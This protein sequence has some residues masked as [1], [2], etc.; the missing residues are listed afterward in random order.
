MQPREFETSRGYATAWLCNRVPMHSRA[1]ATARLCNRV[2]VHARG[3]AT[4]W[5]CNCVAM[6]LR[7][8]AASLDHVLKI[9][10]LH[11]A[12]TPSFVGILVWVLA[13]LAARAL[14]HV[15]VRTDRLLKSE[16]VYWLKQV[17]VADLVCFPAV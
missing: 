9:L 16:W 5:L 1:Y 14:L 3:Y 4:E 10:G 13:A 15:G 8:Y 17:G 6:Q 12:L 7:G 11:F 2:A